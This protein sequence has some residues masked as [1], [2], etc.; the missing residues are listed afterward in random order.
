M[1]QNYA[2]TGGAGFI[3]SNLIHHLAS[4]SRSV[5]SIDNYINGFTDN[6]INAANVEYL[7]V[8]I[9]N[10]EEL[11]EA[12]VGCDTV[13]HLA[14]LGSVPRSIKAPLPTFDV[15]LAGSVSVLEAA[16]AAGCQRVIYASSSS[17]YGDAVETIKAEGAEGLP[18]SPY[19][20][21]K[22]A[23]ELAARTHALCYDLET[24]GLRFFNVFGPNQRPETTYAAVVPLFTRALLAGDRPIV[25]GDGCQVRD[26]TYVDD[27]IQALTRAADAGP[28]TTGAVFNVSGGAG[29]TVLELLSA[30]GS[31]VGTSD[32]TADHHPS[33]PGDIRT[34]RADITAAKVGLGFEPTWTLIDGIKEY[35]AWYK[36]SYDSS[37]ESD[38]SR[39]GSQY[40]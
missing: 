18:I 11:T 32:Y 3:G 28:E 19:A 39:R 1:H 25:F 33:R 16:R 6:H 31:A 30:I 22:S 26:F 36:A 2:V 40:Q 12:F 4:T 29:A 7:R 8:D 35:V 20:A 14:A 24:V 13:F 5:I 23:M 38:V 21:S 34:S 37:A 17:V 15:N 10:T 9:R 27:V